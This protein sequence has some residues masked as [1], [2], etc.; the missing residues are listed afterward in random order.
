MLFDLF[1]LWRPLFVTAVLVLEAAVGVLTGGSLTSSVVFVVSLPSTVA[2][3]KRR[4][5]A[6]DSG[7]VNDIGGAK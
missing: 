3:F 6:A 5:V 2:G 7:P 1:G 4:I